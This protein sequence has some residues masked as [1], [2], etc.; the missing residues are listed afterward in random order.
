MSGWTPIPTRPAVGG[1][2]TANL[3]P[4]GERVAR[5]ALD[6][7]L[8]WMDGGRVHNWR[9]YI[10]PRVRQLWASLND[11]MKIALALDA[12]EIAG[13]EEWD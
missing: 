3:L 10:G 13:N 11:D 8:N 2:V 5:E 1:P 7:E 4:E 12:D 6:P 9:S